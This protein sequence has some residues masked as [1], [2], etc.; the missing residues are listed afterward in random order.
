VFVQVAPVWPSTLADEAP[1]G[2]VAMSAGTLTVAA[3]TARHYR[4]VHDYNGDGQSD[5][6]VYNGQLGQWTVGSMDGYAIGEGLFGGAAFEAV[7]GD[8]DGDGKTDPVVYVPSSGY[9]MGAL[10]GSGYAVIAGTFGGPTFTPVCADYDGDGRTDPALFDTATGQWYVWSLGHG[11]LAAGIRFTG[12]TAG[13]ERSEV[14][15]QR[16]A[17]TD[18]RSLFVGPDLVSGRMAASI[19]LRQCFAGQELAPYE[20]THLDASVHPSS[21]IL[22]SSL[23]PVPG[24]YNG[25][26]AADLGVYDE[27]TGRWYAR[28]L[29]G[30]LLLWDAF[31]GSPGFVPVPGDYDGDRRTIWR[32]IR[33]APAIGISAALP[34]RCCSGRGGGGTGIHARARRL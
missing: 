18:G 27:S 16:S 21:L 15:S 29:G 1:G 22:P 28:S 20:E 23:L 5:L 12:A 26:G 25:D 3:T 19:R 32:S 13:E 33:R 17:E 30:A 11:W 7:D 4:P 2:N 14:G 6:A 24:D 10:S 34:V 31:W 8:Y 9:W